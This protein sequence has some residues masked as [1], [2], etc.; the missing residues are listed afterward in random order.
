LNP[1]ANCTACT[2]AI[3]VINAR[4]ISGPMAGFQLHFDGSPVVLFV[5]RIPSV[6]RIDPLLLRARQS[7][8]SLLR[9]W[10]ISMARSAIFSTS[11]LRVADRFCCHP[12]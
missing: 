3:N 12:L 9:F 6:N 11:H 4:A 10:K 7:H 1:A 2:S 8:D 5:A